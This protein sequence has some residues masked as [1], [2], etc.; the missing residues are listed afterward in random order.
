MGRWREDRGEEGESRGSVV[1]SASSISVSVYVWLCGCLV[2]SFLSAV[3][4]RNI[5]MEKE[6][7]DV[8]KTR[9]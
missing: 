8:R 5:T 2:G 7:A 6:S 9:E 3:T 1:Q 4:Q